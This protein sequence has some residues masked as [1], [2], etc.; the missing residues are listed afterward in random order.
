MGQ[1]GNIQ[2]IFLM[3]VTELVARLEQN[4]LALDGAPEDRGL[5]EEIFRDAHT[6][7]GSAGVAGFA[8]LSGFVHDMESVL[9]GIRQGRLRANA[10]VVSLLLEGVDHVRAVTAALAA[11]EAPPEGDGRA[12][13]ERLRDAASAG[14]GGA[15]G[16][17][18]AGGETGGVGAV[19][20]AAGSGAAAGERALRIAIRLP[21]RLFDTGTDPLLLLHELADLG[22]LAAVR[23]DLSRLP[24][25]EALD[26]T[27]LYL[28][29]DVVLRTT[30]DPA[31]VR[32]VFLFVEDDGDIRVEAVGEEENA[33]APAPDGPAAGDA[34]PP[35]AERGG[36]S[37]PFRDQ[38]GFIKVPV[39]KLDGL[40]NT[41]GELTITIARVSQVLTRHAAGDPRLQGLGEELGML[42]RQLQDQVMS[43]RML[44]LE[45]VFNRFQRLVRDKAAE[46]GKRIRLEVQGA[47]TEMDKSVIEQVA[48]PLKHLIRNALDHGIE[49]PEER[50]RQG[51]PE[52]GTIRLRAYH[53]GGSV[54]VEVEDDGRGIDREKVLDKARR[55]GVVRDGA[56]PGDDEVYQ[57]IFHPGLST[58]ERVT[59]LSGRG[60]GMDVVRTNLAALRGSIDVASAPGRGT[61]FRIRLPL[62][63][64]IIDTL[65]ARVGE[66]V[67]AL[68]KLSILEC[69]Q[70]KR[71]Q[72]KTIEGRGEVIELR[73]EILPLV[74]LAHVLGIAG[75][76]EDPCRALVV[77]AEH[78]RKKL[79]LL[80]DDIIG[81]QQAVVKSL[82]E[83]FVKVKGTAGAAIRGDG[84]VSLIADIA[85]IARLAFA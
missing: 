48:D 53:S 80:V 24:D 81:D 50:R 37:R 23:P 71:R 79:C 84:S 83:N 22:E 31:E 52:Q 12:L 68:P 41:T 20:G 10:R 30:A 14:D 55:M 60:V 5:I 32:G 36:A 56:E 26:P 46:M 62:T 13:G 40:V 49:P 35:A 58:A 44:P 66:T 34:A 43:L 54:V 4:L 1:A 2:E 3:E 9:D 65:E 77:V 57:L 38:A 64:A 76:A 8:A 69:L 67:I 70:P 16:G 28:G 33:S 6:I 75:A 63:L 42:A 82:E 51:K 72:Y 61:L 74:R 21:E 15:S 73:G 39:P 27:A 47:E 11:G 25:L 78:G 17:G 7:K 29:W 59:D 85:G 19:G 18:G 45:G